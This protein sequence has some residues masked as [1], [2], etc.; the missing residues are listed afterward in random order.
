[1][2]KAIWQNLFK[3]LKLEVDVVI[4]LIPFSKLSSQSYK[5]FLGSSI[6]VFVA[7]VALNRAIICT[8][9]SSYNQQG[10]HFL[11]NVLP[12]LHSPPVHQQTTVSLKVNEDGPADAFLSKLYS[13]M[14]MLIKQEL[15]P[16]PLRQ[17]SHTSFPNPGRAPNSKHKTWKQ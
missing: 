5:L 12:F 10:I 4:W 3:I 11:I 8:Q 13:F 7:L 1:M 14:A 6:V 2:E 17:T 15:S 9:P 16:F